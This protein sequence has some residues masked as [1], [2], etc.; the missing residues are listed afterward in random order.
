MG[1]CGFCYQNQKY[2][3]RQGGKE[4][5]H[6]AF[7][8]KTKSFGFEIEIFILRKRYF[9]ITSW[10]LKLRQ[11]IYKPHF[12]PTNKDDVEPSTGCTNKAN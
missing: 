5:N 12:I 7:G 6:I 3:E 4:D 2:G 8:E 10:L 11:Q 9:E 1:F